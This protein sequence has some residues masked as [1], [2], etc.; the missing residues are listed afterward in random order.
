MPPIKKNKTS[1]PQQTAEKIRRRIHTQG[2]KVGDKLPTEPNLMVEFNV[3][4]ALM[5]A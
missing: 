5:L 4:H 3:S 2:M 1:L